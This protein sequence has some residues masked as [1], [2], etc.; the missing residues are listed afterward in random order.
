[1]IE[2]DKEACIIQTVNHKQSWLEIKQI[3]W[4]NGIQITDVQTV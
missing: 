2:K 4:V 3:L 1:M